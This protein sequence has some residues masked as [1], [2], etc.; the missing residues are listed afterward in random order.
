MELLQHNKETL[1]EVLSFINKKESCCIVN[2]CG[3]GKTS[4]I[5]EVINKFK[6]NSFVIFTKQINAKSYYQKNEI[7]CRSNVKII[8]YSKM[9]IDY[10]KNKID[11]FDADYWIADEA[12]YI[13]ADKWNEAFL[14]LRNKFKPIV[15]GVTATP[16]RFEDQGSDESVVTRYFNGNMAGGFSISDLQ[17]SNIFVEPKYVLS[18]EGFDKIISEKRNLVYELGVAEK[19]EKKLNDLLNE[20]KAESSP[21]IVIKK[22]VPKYVQ[23]K[24]NIIL[25]YSPDT[26][27]IKEHKKYIDS[28]VKEAC[29]KKDIVS[30]I[31]THKSSE[32]DFKEFINSNHKIKI[33]YSIDKITETLHLDD[34]NVVIMLRPSVSNRI[35]TQQFGRVNNCYNS[36]ECLIIDMVN[37][38]NHINCVDFFSSFTS[39]HEFNS[40]DKKSKN[41]SLRFARNCLSV[42]DA[43][44][45]IPNNAVLFSIDGKMLTLSQIAAMYNKNLDSLKLA[46]NETG[47]VKEAISISINEVK[48]VSQAVFDEIIEIPDFT[49]TEESRKNFEKYEFI[50]SDLIIRFNISDDMSQNLYLFLCYIVSSESE[51]LNNIYVRQ[52]L[53]SWY[54]RKEV[55]IKRRSEVISPIYEAYNISYEMYCDYDNELLRRHLEQFFKSL[56]PREIKLLKFRYGFED[57]SY[58]SLA[59]A[60]TYLNISS[61]RA[62]QI[63]RKVFRRNFRNMKFNPCWISEDSYK[64]VP[65]SSSFCIGDEVICMFPEKYKIQEPKPFIRVEPKPIKWEKPDLT[66][67]HTA[68][69]WALIRSGK[70]SR[71]VATQEA[72]EKVLIE[73]SRPIRI[74]KTAMINSFYTELQKQDSV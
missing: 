4:V 70:I 55:L 16:Q 54:F 62:S 3:S 49:M 45:K 34:L 60:G 51:K 7:F 46:Y 57:D 71:S 8:T 73:S 20:W 35:I 28:L 9:L 47:D 6:D 37:N 11:Y 29:R 61:M 64:Q 58:H 67:Y 33:L 59:E 24:K 13:G 31:Y 22:Y 43:I 1:Q 36:K 27:T 12:H 53:Q 68:R 14:Y 32:V 52:R 39:S 17:K 30:Y 66:G 56:S 40:S 69:E 74:N 26:R 63:E 2:P 50:V 18:I 10:K 15:I 21:E 38:L 25:V 19:Y 5:A 42:F 48:S 65:N 44:S 41:F 23:D 72:I